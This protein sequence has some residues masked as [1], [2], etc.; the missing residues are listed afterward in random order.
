MNLWILLIMV[1]NKNFVPWRIYS[2][3]FNADMFKRVRILEKLVT[4]DFYCWNWLTMFVILFSDFRNF[5]TVGTW[6]VSEFVISCMF[7]KKENTYIQP[8]YADDF[9][10]LEIVA[11]LSLP[12][13]LEMPY[14]CEKMVKMIRDIQIYLIPA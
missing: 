5:S 6:I 14:F 13:S 1:L 7:C 8:L 4:V 11:C 2:S 3:V 9:W 10:M 12:T